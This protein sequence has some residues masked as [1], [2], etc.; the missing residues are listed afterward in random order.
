VTDRVKGPNERFIDSALNDTAMYLYLLADATA[1]A[2]YD[3]Y[4]DAAD[5]LLDVIGMWEDGDQNWT[6]ST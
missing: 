1:G 2:S 6:V 4:M 5:A 3:V